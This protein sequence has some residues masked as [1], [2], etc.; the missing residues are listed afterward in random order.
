[1]ELFRRNI[2]GKI[3]NYFP[4]L[5][6]KRSVKWGQ[7]VYE[8]NSNVTS[9]VENRKGEKQLGFFFRAS[10]KS[11]KNGFVW[12][13]VKIKK[14]ETRECHRISCKFICS[15]TTNR[16]RCLLAIFAADW[17]CHIDR[18][19]LFRRFNSFR[20]NYLCQKHG[21][22]FHC[23]TMANAKKVTR[24]LKITSVIHWGESIQHELMR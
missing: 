1:M 16:L 11:M 20:S 18:H 23:V 21:I 8:F 4:R 7:S 6:V 10:V 17:M 19:F 15:F 13:P 14:C 5:E 24:N 9:H 12:H 22:H 3:V 2:G